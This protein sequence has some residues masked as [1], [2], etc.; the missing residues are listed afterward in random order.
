V[1]YGFV[2]PPRDVCISKPCQQPTMETTIRE[3]TP[4]PAAITDPL[5]RVSKA[6]YCDPSVT[7]GCLALPV[8]WYSDAEIN[9]TPDPDYV[10]I[11][12]I[13]TYDGWRNITEAHR[14]P[15]PGSA[16]PE[17]VTKATYDCTRRTLCAKPQTITD[18]RNNITSYS[19][20]PVH[21]GVLT[22]TG[23]A[24]NGVTPQKRYTY[25]ARSAR[26][27]DGSAAPGAA[28]VYVLTQTSICRT[29]NPAPSGTGCALPGD[30]VVTAYDYGPDSGP[31]NLLLRSTTLDAT[32]LALRTC[33]QWDAA[34]NKV[35]ETSP[36]GAISGC[37]A[38]APALL[39]PTRATTR[40]GG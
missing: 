11:R 36:L 35:A 15:R 8:Q 37:P 9:T 30:E 1:E 33:Y 20:D 19:Y 10:G 12:T 23:P 5:N 24:V 17:V 7:S 27:S 21:G 40:H 29:G 28:A 31:N 13:L 4:G 34:G 39:P 22:E 26:L 3:V 38:S 25:A 32:G 2:V 6:D 18:A 16:L 14:R